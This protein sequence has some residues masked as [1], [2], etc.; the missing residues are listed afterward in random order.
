[1]PGASDRTAR[2]A[3][4]AT[5]AGTTAAATAPTALRFGAAVW[6][7]ELATDRAGA[8]VAGAEASADL[9]VAGADLGAV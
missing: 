4:P 6:A 2:L 7:P 3:N 1:M 9:R 8:A 5:T